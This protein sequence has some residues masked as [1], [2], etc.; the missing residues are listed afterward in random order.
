MFKKFDIK[1]QSGQSQVKTSVIRA[2]RTQ[3][4]KNYPGIESHLDEILPK[5]ATLTHVKFKGHVSLY[6]IDEV[7]I[8]FQ[9]FND[10]IVPSL[11]LVHQFPD[12]LP[13][14]QVDRGAIKYVLSGANI[15]CPGL[16]SA[17]AELPETNLEENKVVAIKAEGKEHALAIGVLKMSTDDIKKV[18][19]GT[20]VEL[21]HY[22]GD[23]LWKA[24][25]EDLMRLAS[26]QTARAKNVALRKKIQKQGELDHRNSDIKSKERI[27]RELEA[28]ERQRQERDRIEARAKA[29]RIYNKT[30]TIEKNNVSPNAQKK[31]TATREAIAVGNP[32]PVNRNVRKGFPGRTSSSKDIKPRPISH[33]RH[34]SSHQDVVKPKQEK[35]ALSY[36]ELLKIADNNKFRPKQ[37]HTEPNYKPRIPSSAKVSS[38]LLGKDSS[39]SKE[40]MISDIKR[41]SRPTIRSKDINEIRK[42]SNQAYISQQKMLDR[43][44]TSSRNQESLPSSSHRSSPITPTPAPPPAKSSKPSS[45]FKSPRELQTTKPAVVRPPPKASQRQPNPVNSNR[46]SLYSSPQPSRKSIPITNQHR[47]PAPQ[48]ST[49]KRPL[50]D[51]R[52][53]SRPKSRRYGHSDDEYGDDDNDSMDDFIVDDD[54]EEDEGYGNIS[55]Y[56]SAHSRGPHSNVPGSSVTE[57]I[58]RIFGY[59]KNRYKDEVFDDDD[60][61]MES[62]AMDQLHEE[63]RSAM[64]A[65]KEDK[66]EEMLEMERMRRLQEKRLAKK[67]ARSAT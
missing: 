46:G 51:Q 56:S 22:L 39:L 11:R 26:S 49:L 50:N 27:Q 38:G 48:R 35:S 63:K 33:T 59:N 3:W 62:S 2:I 32:S 40:G 42:T 41:E 58:H 45:G 66:R 57:E 4:I 44:P 24:W 13:T 20:G 18:N 1:D 12:I 28:R 25:Y 30:A 43:R 67:R 9:M 14:V 7:V 54:E 17:G 8:A 15:M 5:K 10:P 37:K 53:S 6:K 23:Q 64:I 60:D 52:G 16:T 65:I 34:T 29:T 19:K 21:Y 61:I 47:I 55:H 36:G 31:S